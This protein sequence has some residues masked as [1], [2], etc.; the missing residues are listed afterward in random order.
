MGRRKR[1]ETEVTQ[2]SPVVS[3][4]PD[5]PQN[6]VPI[7]MREMVEN[8]NTVK[9]FCAEHPEID[10]EILRILEDIGSQHSEALFNCAR[11]EENILVASGEI[12][13]L[14]TELAQKTNQ[15]Q[16]AALKTAFFSHSQ[17]PYHKA[18]TTSSSVRAIYFFSPTP[19][20]FEDT[21]I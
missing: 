7:S 9:K 10:T 14:R 21:P 1:T 18:L 15:F 11:M 4:P 6:D 12:V 2:P 19:L 13:K 5:D 3:V 17:P 20:H 8:L 16:C